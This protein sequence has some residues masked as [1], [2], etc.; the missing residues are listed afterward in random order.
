VL[1][2]HAPTELPHNFPKFYG[3]H[4]V[5]YIRKENLRRMNVYYVHVFENFRQF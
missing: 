3:E 4:I 1:G 2:R 5:F